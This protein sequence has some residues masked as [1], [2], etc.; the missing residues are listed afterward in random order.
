MGKWVVRGTMTFSEKI[1][2]LFSL[3]LFYGVPLTISF[4]SS[5][6]HVPILDERGD[7]SNWAALVVEIAIGTC[8]AVSI[9][10][11][12]NHQQKK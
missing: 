11:Y 9:L 3:V 10:V 4:V 1:L 12:S 7:V 6:Y 2:V 5:I 8:I